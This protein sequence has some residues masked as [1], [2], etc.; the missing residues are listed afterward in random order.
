MTQKSV[1]TALLVSLSALAL[2]PI[3]KAD[4]YQGVVSVDTVEV[5][6]NDHFG[7]A[8]RLSNNDINV[9]GL[10][11]PL[12]FDGSDLAF[13]SVSFVGSFITSDV[14]GVV[15]SEPQNNYIQ[16]TYLPDIAHLPITPIPAPN[17]II[18]TVYFTVSGDADPAVVTIDSVNQDSPIWRKVHLSDESGV[19]TFMPAF[20]EGAVKIV[21]PTAVEDCLE[22]SLPTSFGLAQN[23]PNPFNPS[24]VIEFSLPASSRAKLE[25]FNILGQ[26]IETLVDRQMAAGTHRVEFNASRQPSGVYFYRLT[27]AEGSHTR[28]MVLVK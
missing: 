27:H 13:D 19:G 22:T 14:N 11:V 28:K 26:K 12:H 25:V 7:V 8:V 24:T 18:A 10:M 6:R 5:Y 23:Y 17:G 3:A 2:A 4:P 20:I 16:I 21:V 15:Y 9:A 1:I